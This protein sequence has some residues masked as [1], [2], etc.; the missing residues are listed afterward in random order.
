MSTNYSIQKRALIPLSLFALCIMVF[1]FAGCG[2]ASTGAGGAATSTPAATPV[3]TT[4]KGF[5]SVHGCPSDIVVDNTPAQANV[6]LQPSDANTMIT[7]H[8][9]DV[10]EVRLPFGHK[11]SEP[12]APQGVLQLQTPAGYAF[13]TNNACIWRFVAQKTGSAQLNF[14]GRPICKPGQ[15]CALFIMSVP[16]KIDVK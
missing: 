9:G 12:A 2:A 1:A 8:S 11:W 10:I 6:I 13:K 3:P 14:S 5:G 7:A 15:M 16:F 4:V